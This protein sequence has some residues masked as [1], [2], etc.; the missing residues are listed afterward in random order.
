MNRERLVN[1]ANVLRKE[2]QAE[3]IIIFGSFI[4]G[5]IREDSDLDFLVI[6]PTQEKFY[7]RLSTVRKLL[8]PY[9]KG[10]RISP[11][12]LTPLEIQE[13]IHKG[14]QFIQDILQNGLSL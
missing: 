8:R 14:D 5:E 10:I 1:L 2:Y 12:V 6:A 11:I 7:N 3:Q 4:H 13:R 9:R